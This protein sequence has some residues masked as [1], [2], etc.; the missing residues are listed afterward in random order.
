M[1]QFAEDKLRACATAISKALRESYLKKLINYFGLIESLQALL[2][3]K[4]V[5]AI[6]PR[7]AVKKLSVLKMVQEWHLSL[8]PSI[9][10]SICQNNQK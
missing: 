2:H 8:V 4:Y 3:K 10:I 6:P 7:T 9:L 1:L 5:Q